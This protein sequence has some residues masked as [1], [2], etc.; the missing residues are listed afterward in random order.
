LNK[1][2]KMLKD[3][4]LRH[5]WNRLVAFRHALRFQERVRM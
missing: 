3:F 5:P 2:E 4:P 1:D